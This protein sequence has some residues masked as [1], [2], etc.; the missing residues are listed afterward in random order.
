MRWTY[1]V[2]VLSALLFSCDQEKKEEAWKAGLEHPFA[3]ARIAALQRLTEKVK[4]G[5]LPYL[6]LAARD[7]E[8]GVR[9]VAAKGL[10]KSRGGQALDLLSSLLMDTDER[11][12][13]AAAAA[14]AHHGSGKAQ[15]YLLL[16]FSKSRQPTRQAIVQALEASGL[17]EPLKQ[18]VQFEAKELWEQSQQT[19]LSPSSLAE[20]VRAAVRLG[21]SGREEAVALLLPLLKEQTPALTVAAV[22]SLAY[23]GAQAALPELEALVLSPHVDIRKASIAAL[24]RLQATSSIPLL[25]RLMAAEAEEEEA[26]LALEGLAHFPSSPEADKAICE[27]AL[28][29]GSLPLRLR[30]ALALEKRAPC[31]PAP[32]WEQLSNPS[33]APTALSVL[34]RWP[35][36]WSQ[37]ANPVW[38][39]LKSTHLGLSALAAH[40]LSQL[41]AQGKMKE[42]PP[43][44]VAFVLERIAA[45][46]KRGERWIKSPLE[47]GFGI[48]TS[49]ESAANTERK[50]RHELLRKKVEARNAAQLEELGQQASRPLLLPELAQNVTQEELAQW[51]AFLKLAS[52]LQP[53]AVEEELK[54]YVD[55]AEVSLRAVALAAWVRQ[56]PAFWDLAEQGIFDQQKEVRLALAEAFV[57]RGFEGEKRL[58][59]ALKKRAEDSTD[60]LSMLSCAQLDEESAQTV[61]AFLDKS[62]REASLAARC[63]GQ[64]KYTAAQDRLLLLLNSTTLAEKKAALEALREM[65]A[66]A[67]SKE[68]E[69]QLFH[70][71]PEIREAAARA[72]CYLRF[73]DSKEMLEALREDYFKRVRQHGIC[74]I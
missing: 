58:L 3:E 71:S 34:M 41:Y 63:L 53:S 74:N 48:P 5:D 38:A 64:A 66:K 11:V 54:R 46:S 59:A 43:E 26:L 12:Q 73:G 4:P 40:G 50:Q 57:Q 18:A 52:F 35:D 7:A 36:D 45:F 2:L 47:E 67:V 65:E 39:L 72:L 51:V 68:I 31:S 44:H 1:V 24:G 37:E 16:R 32:L 69:N 28:Q 56:G 10:G 30:A 8:P 14:M 9:M 55:E 27:L 42:A 33:L 19:L 17:P 29:P 15:Q 21:E 6:A 70:E 22:E 23:L 20:Q 25:R 13:V 61:M 62:A 60:L 49:S